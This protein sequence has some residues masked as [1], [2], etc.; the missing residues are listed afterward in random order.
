MIHRL[1]I[2]AVAAFLTASPASAQSPAFKDLPAR[3]EVYS[4]PP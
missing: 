2:G 1:I 4:L 3:V